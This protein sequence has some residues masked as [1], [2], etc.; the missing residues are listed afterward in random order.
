MTPPHWELCA[1]IDGDTGGKG[2]QTESPRGKGVQL[3]TKHG[4]LLTF[5]QDVVSIRSPC[6]R[7]LMRAVTTAGA[8]SY[9]KVIIRALMW[10]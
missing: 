2:R 4:E 6:A 8:K 7:I 10:Q 1:S 5:A 3:Q 9:V